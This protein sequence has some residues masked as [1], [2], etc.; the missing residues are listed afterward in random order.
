MYRR[1]RRGVLA[2]LGAA[3]GFAGCSGALF[4]NTPTPTPTSATLSP[5]R[6]YGYTH[7]Q[8]SGN[9]VLDG[10]GD[11]HGVEPI[12][13]ETETRPT[14]LVALPGEMG[15]LWTVV[16]V[17]DDATTYRVADG[18]ATEIESH[19]ALPAGMPPLSYSTDEGSSVL[20]GGSVTA[21]RTHPVVTEAGILSIA[22]D[23]DLVLRGESGVRRFPVSALPDGRIVHVG[24]SDYALLGD[25]TNRYGHGALGNQ[26]EGGSIVFFDASVPDVTA[27]TRVGP[28]EVIEGLAPMVADLDGDG[29]PEVIVTVADSE[30]GARIAVYDRDGRRRARGPIYGPGWRHQLAVAPFAGQGP[31]L[32]VTQK[33]HVDHVVEF[34]RLD[35]SQLSIVAEY[36]N[37][38]SHTYGS[39][40]T[41]QALAGD[42]DGD[43]TV[44]LLVPAVGRDTLFVVERTAEGARTDW[45]F[46][47]DAPLTS[48]LAGVTLPDGRLA[49]G[50]G[51]DRGLRVWQG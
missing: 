11:V 47:L 30:N 26:E 40:N 48:N 29:E 23:G 46:A 12:T 33:P 44:E 2:G 38:E 24:G 39:Y 7:V 36:P 32:A 5:D 28:P 31:E 20:R 50:A 21:N 25:A 37:V 22:G 10:S 42:F 16:G 17:L 51:T 19:R 8:P 4:G 6:Q 49:V 41:D 13:L 35:D 34:Y 27:R 9:R 43:G 45:Q 18:E 14:W 15:S 1:S 3:V